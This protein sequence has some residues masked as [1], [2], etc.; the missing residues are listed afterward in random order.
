MRE[1]VS[2]SENTNSHGPFHRSHHS[3]YKGVIMMTLQV[4]RTPWYSLLDFVVVCLFVFFVFFF[5][6]CAL[7]TQI[8]HLSVL[9]VH[10]CHFKCPSSYRN[11][12]TFSSLTKLIKVPGVCRFQAVHHSR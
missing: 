5:F 10:N 4:V 9:K 12:M 8:G 1:F 3:D 2:N 7:E 11:T 6:N